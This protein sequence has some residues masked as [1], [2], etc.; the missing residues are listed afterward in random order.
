MANSNHLFI[1]LIGR[2]S[3]TANGN[4]VLT[5]QSSSWNLLAFLSLATDMTVTRSRLATHLWEAS[6]EVRA[7]R[8]LRQILFRMRSELAGHSEALVSERETVSLNPKHVRTDI[9]EIYKILDGGN[10]PEVVVTT[11]RI[12]EKLLEQRNYFGELS[13]SWVHLARS[14]FENRLQSGLEKL[15]VGPDEY[16]KIRAAKALLCLDAADETA[17]CVLIET[18]WHRG[19]AGRA[20]GIYS[21][22][23]AHLDQEFDIEPG[24]AAKDLIVRIKTEELPSQDKPLP[25]QH[26][27]PKTLKTDIFVLPTSLTT[28][29]EKAAA[30]AG[31]FRSDVISNL[32][33]FRQF[34]IRDASLQPVNAKFTLDLKFD[35]HGDHLRMLATLASPS[36]GNIV[37]S[38]CFEDIAGGWWTHQRKLAGKLAAACATTI[39]ATRLE[40]IQGG[41]IERTALDNWLLGQ[42][43]MLAFRSDQLKAAQDS[44]AKC[45]QLAPQSSLGHSA[46]SQLFN[47]RHLIGPD[48][49]MSD[50]MFRN[51]R[52]YANT[53]IALDPL[54]T[55]AHLCRAWSSCLL[56]E[57]EQ[58]AASFD[59]AQECNIHDPWTVISAALGTAFCGDIAKAEKLLALFNQNRW[60]MTFQ[61]WGYLATIRFLSGDYHGCISAAENGSGVV[62]N[63]LGW[64]AAA[65]WH[66]GETAQANATWS[67]FKDFFRTPGVVDHDDRIL[68][69][70]LACFPIRSSHSRDLLAQGIRGAAT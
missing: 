35:A 45:I 70:F 56:R 49:E 5:R 9:G 39:S 17:A 64:Q 66:L 43:Q 47:G 27:N 69:W 44:F 41:Q 16:E 21:D 14:E 25:D 59:M 36:D 50:E 20:L 4:N 63:V 53:A 54:D 32:L 7:R 51:S 15:L 61:N 57:Y 13:S 12:H 38:E 30:T 65:H 40:A 67:V 37:W 8:N 28:L 68:D 26:R 22:L 18:Y 23:W 1:S 52:G 55:K 58:A 6:D 62:K 34:R 46:M 19:D 2:F 42:S 11:P 60:I 3:A 24:N 31:L 29:P 33:K 48:I 10:V